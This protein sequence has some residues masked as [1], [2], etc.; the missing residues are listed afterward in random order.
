M[1]IRDSFVIVLGLLSACS[2]SAP[3]LKSSA[4]AKDMDFQ[5]ENGADK[6]PIG[7]VS[8]SWDRDVLKI[9][10]KGETQSCGGVEWTVSHSVEN[11]A[12]KIVAAGVGRPM[13]CPMMPVRF[14]FLIPGL[15]RKEYRIVPDI[16]IKWFWD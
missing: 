6:E 5:I 8:Q 13:N 15:P 14:H 4:K 11:D 10:V 12:V 16:S 7:A 3:S 9:S 1:R 2:R